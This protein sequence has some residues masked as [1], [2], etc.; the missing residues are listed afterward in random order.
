MQESSG[1]QSYCGAGIPQLVVPHLL[2]QYYTA[3][4]LELGGVGLGLSGRHALDGASLAE[5]LGRVLRVDMTER[6]RQVATGLTL[7]GEARLVAA[8][9]G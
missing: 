1:P 7:D 6:A 5:A 3:H 8:L 9:T 2:D 4:R